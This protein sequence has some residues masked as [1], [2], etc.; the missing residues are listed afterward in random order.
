MVEESARFSGY[1]RR[2]PESYL[3]GDRDVD[4]IRGDE[5][6]GEDEPEESKGEPFP[7]QGPRE[8]RLGAAY[9]RAQARHEAL[10]GRAEILGS[11]AARR[12]SQRSSSV[13][14]FSQPLYAL[15]PALMMMSSPR[16]KP[17]MA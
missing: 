15:P 14:P 2:M 8:A 4:E 12:A 9:A 1:Q 16:T 17:S 3:K 11:T 7:A 13:V 6:Q 5:A 10:Q